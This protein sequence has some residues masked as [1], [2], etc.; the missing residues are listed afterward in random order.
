MGEGN[1]PLSL[2]IQNWDSKQSTTPATCVI[3]SGV[4]LGSV[5]QEAYKHTH[6]RS[7]SY[8]NSHGGCIHANN[9]TSEKWWELTLYF[10]LSCL[11][12]PRSNQP[13]G[14]QKARHLIGMFILLT[15]PWGK[16]SQALKHLNSSPVTTTACS[17]RE[18]CKN[19]SNNLISCYFVV[20]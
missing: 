16:G 18:I 5:T 13:L 8:H 15:N 6:K 19:I 14:G 20:S 10:W 7:F 3:H 11:N 2:R 12:F 4:H 9:S 17:Q 1:V